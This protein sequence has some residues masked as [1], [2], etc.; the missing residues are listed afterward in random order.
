MR[1]QIAKKSN[2]PIGKGRLITSCI[3]NLSIGPFIGKKSTIN[4]I[5]IL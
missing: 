3:T 1:T 4:K 2:S 5:P